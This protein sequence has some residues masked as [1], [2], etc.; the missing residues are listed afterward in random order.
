MNS[1]PQ[2][3]KYHQWLVQVMSQ[4]VE[5]AYVISS[6]KRPG[7]GRRKPVI[8]NVP[9]GPASIRLSE[10]VLEESANERDRISEVREPSWTQ[11]LPKT[12]YLIHVN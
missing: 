2:A 9:T 12:L 4:A 11:I 10:K 3:V 6:N 1:K 5:Q 8:I 7:P